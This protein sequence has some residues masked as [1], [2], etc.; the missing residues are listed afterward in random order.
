MSKTKLSISINASRYQ[1]VEIMRLAQINMLKSA[2][3]IWALS[4]IYTPSANIC[5]LFS[6]MNV[7]F[8]TFILTASHSIRSTPFRHEKQNIRQQTR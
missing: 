8:V 1:F 3:V 2:W 4:N 5:M 7:N 6:H